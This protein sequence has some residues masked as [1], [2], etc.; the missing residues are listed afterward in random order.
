[1]QDKVSWMG[2]GGGGGVIVLEY[3]TLFKNYFVI[4]NLY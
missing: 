2:I 1:M 3:N 4:F